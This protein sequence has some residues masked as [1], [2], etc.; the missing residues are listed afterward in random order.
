VLRAALDAL[1]VTVA[2]DGQADYLGRGQG[3]VWVPALTVAAMIEGAALTADRDPARASRYLAVAR[4]A[5][6]RL[7]T[8]HEVPGRGLRVVPGERSGVAGMDRYVHTV[9]YNGLALWG[10]SLAADLADRLPPLPAGALPSAGRLTVLDAD[11]SGLAVVG[12]GRT[13]LAMRAITMRTVRD[14]RASFGLLALKVRRG[15]TWRDLLAPRPKTDA[16]VRPDCPG[17]A[18]VFDGAP[19]LPWGRSARIEG[20]TVTVAGHYRVAHRRAFRYSVRAHSRGADVTTWPIRRGERHR[21][22]IFTPAGTGFARGRRITVG[23]TRFAFSAPIEVHRRHG[24][25]SGPIENL[26]ALVVETRATH[27]GRLVIRIS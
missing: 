6:D 22:L 23:G 16:T 13:W 2:P 20:D 7:V 25:H 19:A 3:N 15:G 5:L 18:L 14:L 21:L 1:S 4:A 26:D 9:A 24:Y 10:L 8:L 12:T 27:D 11:A 17:P